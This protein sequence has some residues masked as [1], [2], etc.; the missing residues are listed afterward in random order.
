LKKKQV[1][2]NNSRALQKRGT[3]SHWTN[4]PVEKPKAVTVLTT[5]KKS[6]PPAI[7]VGALLTTYLLSPRW[8]LLRRPNAPGL[9]EKIML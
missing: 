9:A 8:V 4:H 5:Q 1:R 2:E 7:I 3:S 6:R